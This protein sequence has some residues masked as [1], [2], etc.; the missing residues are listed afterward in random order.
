M[1]RSDRPWSPVVRSSRCCSCRA[2]MACGGTT[3]RD[4]SLSPRSAGADESAGGEL[5]A[6]RRALAGQMRSIAE[7][8][9]SRVRAL[10]HCIEQTER[11]RQDRRI[12]ASGSG[13]HDR[14]VPRTLDDEWQ[15]EGCRARLGRCRQGRLCPSDQASRA[16]IEAEPASAENHRSASRSSRPRPSPCPD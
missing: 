14:I 11:R 12:S 13:Q 10:A 5:P 2:G 8:T 4:Y 6:R 1:P 15:L 16:G 3:V 9:E 7:R